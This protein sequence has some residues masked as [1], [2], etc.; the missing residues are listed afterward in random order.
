MVEKIDCVEYE[1]IV[2]N[3]TMYNKNDQQ[4]Q[5]CYDDLEKLLFEIRLDR[6]GGY[7]L[8]YTG[9]KPLM[10]QMSNTP[11]PLARAYLEKNPL[12]HENEF[13]QISIFER[14]ARCKNLRIMVGSVR[15]VNHSCKPHCSYRISEHISKSF[16]RLVVVKPIKSEDEVNVFYGSDFFGKNNCDCSCDFCGFT[17]PQ[18]LPLLSFL[19]HH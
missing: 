3:N 15:F 13:K 6:Y 9:T 11:V 4:L 10:S 5:N 17:V 18:N 7:G 16:V 1:N 8:F 12:Y 2:Q 14:T 19:F